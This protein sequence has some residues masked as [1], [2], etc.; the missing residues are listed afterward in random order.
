MAMRSVK[1]PD[2]VGARRMRHGGVPQKYILSEQGRRLLSECY[3]GTSA[4]ID[5][6][7]RYLG[8]PRY[9][10]HRWAR[11]MH[12][13]GSRGANWAKE[14]IAYLEKHINSKRSENIAAHLG[15]TTGAVKAKARQLGINVPDG[16]SLDEVRQGMGCA[17]DTAN[18]WVRRGYLKG[19]RCAF[20]DHAWDFTD[21]QIR[22]FIRSHPEEI[23]LRRVEKL[24]FLDVCL[25]L[26]RLDNTY[27][28]GTDLRHEPAE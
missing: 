27:K 7:Q 15:R 5:E 12:L 22:D 1:S 8:V 20:N 23:D 19:T 26:G 24:W 13:T 28:A 11:E 14:E 17:W 21:A 25:D 3:D 4:R 2:Q 16:Y 18:K 10:V 9:I 6:L